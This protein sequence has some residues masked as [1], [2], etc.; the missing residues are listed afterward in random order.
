MPKVDLQQALITSANL[1]EVAVGSNCPQGGDGGHGGRTV[2]RL[3]NQGGTCASVRVNGGQAIGN[4]GSA[5]GDFE[6]LELVLAGDC[7]HET[8]IAALEFALD[9]LKKNRQGKTGAMVDSLTRITVE[10]E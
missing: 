2:F 10:V 1:L 5:V 3:T 9:S 6:S 8:F 7:E 4:I